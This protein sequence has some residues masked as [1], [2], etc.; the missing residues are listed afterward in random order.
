MTKIEN[1][2]LKAKKSNKKLK[3][4]IRRELFAPFE[5]KNKR[6]AWITPYVSH[7]YTY[8]SYTS[9]PRR[10]KALYSSKRLRISALSA[11]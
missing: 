4:V 7:E 1:K 2:C 8:N 3:K 9:A 10:D 11:S 5:S 6:D